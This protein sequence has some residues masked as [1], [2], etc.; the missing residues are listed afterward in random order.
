MKTMKFDAISKEVLNDTK[1]MNDNNECKNDVLTIIANVLKIQLETIDTSKTLSEYGC[2]E[3]KLNQIAE[4][5]RTSMKITVDTNII[6]CKDTINKFIDYVCTSNEKVISAER[7]DSTP[8]EQVITD[9]DAIQATLDSYTSTGVESFGNQFVGVLAN[10]GDCFLRVGNNIK[11]NITRLFS[12]T[13]RSEIKNYYEGHM[14]LCNRVES[15]PLEHL[16]SIKVDVPTGMNKTEYTK[17]I[18]ELQTTYEKLDLIAF[19]LVMEKQFC[20]LR[21]AVSRETMDFTEFNAMLPL[22]SGREKTMNERN[23]VMDKIFTQTNI[24][25]KR[26]FIDVYKTMADFKAT[27]VNLINMQNHIDEANQLMNIVDDASTAIGDIT[28]LI[29]TNEQID[30]KVIENMIKVVKYF[31]EATDAFGMNI[32]RQLA[33]EHNHICNIVASWQAIKSL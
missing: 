25:I 32:S 15:E 26:D 18:E 23:K 24:T 31:A 10:I 4:N 1:Q 2:D 12:T 17:A 29:E 16:K 7:W 28:S 22:I 9:L 21:A 5:I 20:R 27:R 11:T 8:I 30:K 19:A 33:T 3:D 14:L 6:S 13:K